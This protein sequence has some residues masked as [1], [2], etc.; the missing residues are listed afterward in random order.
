MAQ[1]FFGWLQA[2][3]EAKST[4]NGISIHPSI[5]L[6]THPYI[7][8]YLYFFFFF[9][10]F[11]HEVQLPPLIVVIATPL[12]ALASFISS[13]FSLASG[14]SL[15]LCLDSPGFLSCSRIVPGKAKA[16]PRQP[17]T[18][19]TSKTACSLFC[20]RPDLCHNC[21]PAHLIA[22]E[23]LY[24]LIQVPMPSNDLITNVLA[25]DGLLRCQTAANSLSQALQDGQL[26]TCPAGVMQMYLTPAR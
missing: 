17:A 16:I 19:K 21:L 5:Y 3:P 26:L 9:L 1:L 10:L 2:P 6:S 23:I 22:K 18:A 25:L 14:S 7:H 4:Y 8:V 11:P 12:P 24:L 15:G 13:V 20:F